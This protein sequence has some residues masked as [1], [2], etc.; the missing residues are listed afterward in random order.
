MRLSGRARALIGT[1]VLALGLGVSGLAAAT[2]P[3]PSGPVPTP[4]VA[5]TGKLIWLLPAGKSYG[6]S[7]GGSATV[8]VAVPGNPVPT[9]VL[10][11]GN[12]G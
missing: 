5:G 2:R 6:K 9:D 7:G 12:G 4:V 8:L 3:V 10:H 11:V 1:A